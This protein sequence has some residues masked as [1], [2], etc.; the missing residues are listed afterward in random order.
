MA[1][2]AACVPYA[3]VPGVPAAVPGVPAAVPG[4]AAAAGTVAVLPAAVLRA[5]AFRAVA[6][7]R[8]GPAI[9]SIAAAI[10]SSVPS[11]GPA[12]CTTS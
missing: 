1:A 5:V 12:T 7:P 2:A 6:V 4:V 11:A 8:M 9:W 10:S 3:A